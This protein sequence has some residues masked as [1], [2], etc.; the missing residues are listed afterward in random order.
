RASIS[1]T[2]S[3]NLIVLL[4]LIA[5]LLRFQ[6]ADRRTCGDLLAQPQGL[7]PVWPGPLRH[8]KNVPFQLPGRLRDARNFSPQRESTEAQA[9][10]AELAQVGARTSA[11]LA[12]V[13]LARG[14]LGFLRVLNSFRCRC[15][16]A[17][18]SWLLAV[19]SQSSAASQFKLPIFTHGTACP[20]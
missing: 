13:V 3:V 8:D 19:S 17:F 14:E 15:H 5:R 1:A 10:N 9:A 16:L 18:S 12:A 6:L 7:N 2:G 11:N 20:G 4:L